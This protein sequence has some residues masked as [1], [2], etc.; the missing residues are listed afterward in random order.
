MFMS[1]SR[2][3]QGHTY[4]FDAAINSE[5]VDGF[6]KITYIVFILYQG[7]MNWSGSQGRGVKVKVTARS[8]I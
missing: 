6:N 2:S 5:P 4:K 1:R 3:D 8:N 7:Q